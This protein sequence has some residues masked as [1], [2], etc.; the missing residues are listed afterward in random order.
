M[1]PVVVPTTPAGVVTTTPV[2][3]VVVPT[4]PVTTPPTSAPPTTYVLAVSNID[5]VGGAAGHGQATF[6]VNGTSYPNVALTHKFAT[7]FQFYAVD[8][9]QCV[10]VLFGDASHQVCEGNPIQV[11]A[12]S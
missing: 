3:P 2:S 5:P 4:A 12:G 9:T 10:S 11:S 8:N 1:V 6:N 7:Y